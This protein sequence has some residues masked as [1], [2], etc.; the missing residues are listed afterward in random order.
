VGLALIGIHNIFALA[1]TAIAWS[2]SN[3]PGGYW[4]LYQKQ[5]DEWRWYE[6]R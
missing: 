6:N 3:W 2:V 5:S 4:Q 1:V